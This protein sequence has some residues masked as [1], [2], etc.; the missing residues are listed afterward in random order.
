MY[1]KGCPRCG[2]RSTMYLDEAEDNWVC[3][4]CAKRVD[5][6]LRKAHYMNRK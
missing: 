3:I 6:K 2:P 4:Q 5:A 1:K